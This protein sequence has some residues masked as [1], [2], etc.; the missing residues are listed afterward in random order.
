MRKVLNNPNKS[1]RLSGTT[2]GKVG[3]V[4]NLLD[5][6]K[7]T[8]C[9]GDFVKYSSYQ[10]ILLYNHYSDEYGVALDYSMWYGD[11]KYNIDSYGKFLAIPMDN[12]ARMEIEKFSRAVANNH[13]TNC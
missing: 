5:K 11:D 7:E 2:K 8:L 10:G 9:V 4:L 6:N 13:C 12:G 3:T 1:K